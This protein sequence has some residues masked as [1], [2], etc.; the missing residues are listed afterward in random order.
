M[1]TLCTSMTLTNPYVTKLCS[2]Y[3][4]LNTVNESV[5]LQLEMHCLI[6]LCV[7]FPSS[8]NLLYILQTKTNEFC[9]ITVLPPCPIFSFFSAKH[10]NFSAGK[11]PPH[12]SA[13]L[14]LRCLLRRSSHKAKC[15]EKTIVV[16]VKS[17]LFV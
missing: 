10:N 3:C 9:R 1:W 4:L 13:L 14:L 8:E 2:N 6:T 17:F 15:L 7:C 12:C 11:I 16:S 5:C